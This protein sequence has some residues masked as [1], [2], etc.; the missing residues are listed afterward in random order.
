[1]PGIRRNRLL[2]FTLFMLFA[3]A[4]PADEKLWELLRSGGQVVFMRHAITTPGVGD[5]AGFRVEDCAT[6]RNLTAEGKQTARRIGEAFRARG[7]PLGEILSSRWCRC[8]ETA[9]LAFGRYQLWTE[10]NS[11]YQD[12][13]ARD[14][15]TQAVRK[16]VAAHRGPDNLILV[17]HGANIL[18]L[19]GIHPSPG[20]MVILTPGGPDGFHIAGRLEPQDILAPR[21]KR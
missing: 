16:R 1:M 11:L 13:G 15:Q 5:P 20:G 6:Q 19:T 7:V 18:P 2:S 8:T 4:A 3:A 12:P 21:A 14:K 9:Q 10:L 17:S